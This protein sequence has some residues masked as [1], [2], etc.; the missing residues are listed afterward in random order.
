LP[1]PINYPSWCPSIT[2]INY[3]NYPLVVNYAKTLL[4][5]IALYF[6][7]WLPLLITPP[8]PPSNYSI[9]NNPIPYL[10]NYLIYY[11]APSF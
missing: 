5:L 10:I 2:L 7:H 9:I 4:L 11:S 1:H 3:P 6:S 8:L